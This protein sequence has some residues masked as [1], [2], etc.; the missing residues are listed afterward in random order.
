MVQYDTR[1]LNM[2]SCSKL[3]RIERYIYIRISYAGWNWSNAVE[4]L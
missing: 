4:T 3:I 1:T 2:E